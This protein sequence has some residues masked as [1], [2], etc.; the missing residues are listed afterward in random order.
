MYRIDHLAFRT[1]DRQKCVKFFQEALGYRFA[2]EF[3]IVLDEEKNDIATCTI[4]EPSNRIRGDLPWTK[5]FP[6]YPNAIEIMQQEYVLAPE[7][8]ISE[9]SPGSLVHDWAS[10][11]NGGG[12][13]HIALQVSEN[14][15][16]KEEMKKWLDNGW[17]EDFTT[18]EP[19][20][21]AELVQVF[22]RPSS[23]TGIIF[24]LIE[25]KEAGFCRSS[26][27]ELMLSTKN[28]YK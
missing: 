22:T 18:S 26:V 10:K 13:H 2:D 9:G 19:I 4:L 27:R 24:E 12:L 15:S 6:L 14:S 23:I 21:C 16:V 28:D 8:F 17:V 1:L 7:L 3:P 20:V 11:R 25:R 5:M